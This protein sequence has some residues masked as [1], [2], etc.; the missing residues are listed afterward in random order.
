[1]HEA[2]IAASLIEIVK[3]TAANHQAKKVTK[4]FV[5]IGRLAGI[6]IDSLQFAYD[7]IKEDHNIIKDSEIIIEDVRIT[8]KCQ[9]CGVIDTYDEMFFK[10]SK[11]GS[12]EVE[13]LTGEELKITEIEVD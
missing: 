4:V 7:A 9:K 13:L 11:C 10:C 1:M 12:Y 6:E 3:E 8:G 5:Q 2:S